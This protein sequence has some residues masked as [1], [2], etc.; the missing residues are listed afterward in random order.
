MRIFVDTVAE[1]DCW[2]RL[3]HEVCFNFE[4]QV[5]DVHLEVLTPQL[6]GS[7]SAQY[8]DDLVA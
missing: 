8:Q 6:V 4:Q 7:I 2:R 3:C 1:T 5:D